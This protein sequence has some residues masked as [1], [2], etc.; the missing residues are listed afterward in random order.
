MSE[1]DVGRLY[2]LVRGVFRRFEND[3]FQFKSGTFDPGGWEGYQNSLIQDIL[4][5]PGFRAMWQLQ[6]D[7]FAPEFVRFVDEKAEVARSRP[8][9]S[10]DDF[11]NVWK[12]ALENEGA[13]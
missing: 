9:L 7:L 13:A 10:P 8:S 11:A 4:P 2:I 5:F 1:P 3:F 12:A 6:R